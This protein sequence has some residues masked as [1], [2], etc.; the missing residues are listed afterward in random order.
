MKNK[1][2]L[3]IKQKFLLVLILPSLKHRL[4]QIYRKYKEFSLKIFWNNFIK[5]MIYRLQPMYHHDT[6]EFFFVLPQNTF[7]QISTIWKYVQ[8]YKNNIGVVYVEL[9]LWKAK[10]CWYSGLFAGLIQGTDGT[11]TEAVQWSLSLLITEV[12]TKNVLVVKAS[13]S[14]W[15][16]YW[17]FVTRNCS[18][19]A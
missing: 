11:N 7:I 15:S 5:M 8:G 4:Q 18:T 3:N 13:S 10:I 1:T 6:L 12:I 2:I 14:E 16:H 19:S 9:G 17:N